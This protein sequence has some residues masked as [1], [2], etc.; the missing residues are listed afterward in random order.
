MA[1]MG[2]GLAVA[3][4]VSALVLVDEAALDVVVDVEGEGVVDEP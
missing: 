4:S 3:G 2:K 1:I